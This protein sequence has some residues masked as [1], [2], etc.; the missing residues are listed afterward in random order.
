M[1]VTHCSPSKLGLHLVVP[2]SPP[3]PP[4]PVPLILSLSAALRL[5]L[6]TFQ[7]PPLFL[8]L[9]SSDSSPP[10]IPL[11]RYRPSFVARLEAV[12]LGIYLATFVERM[13]PLARV[14]RCLSRRNLASPPPFLPP[15]P[16]CFPLSR[17][18][19]PQLCPVVV[20]YDSWYRSPFVLSLVHAFPVHCP[21]PPCSL[22]RRKLKWLRQRTMLLFVARVRNDSDL[23]ID[24]VKWRFLFF[25]T[26]V[27]GWKSVPRRKE[28]TSSGR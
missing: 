3:P 4:P 23:R 16:S 18:L 25:C 27:E 7:L 22:I 26:T 9:V 14:Q 13:L 10:R 17:W 15:P 5:Q 1:W 6:S 2:P 11:S 28:D 24:K 19:V 8:R 20:L 21:L 12:S